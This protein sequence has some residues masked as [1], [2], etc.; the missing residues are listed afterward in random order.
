MTRALAALLVMSLAAC[1]GSEP[2]PTAIGE[3]VPLGP[4]TLVIKNVSTMP[5]PEDRM[6]I[7]IFVELTVADPQRVFAQSMDNRIRSRNELFRGL[8]LVDGAGE[9]RS[10]FGRATDETYRRH[11]GTYGDP[12]GGFRM[13][14]ASQE[15]TLFTEERER[16]VLLTTIPRTSRG[17]VL[18]MRNPTPRE[19]QAHLM[20]VPLGV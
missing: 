14:A 10:I 3:P 9:K 4:Y 11:V 1:R 13:L 6:G 15:N 12:A 20:A 19:G 18:Q 5:L 8:R 17:H 16:W 2:L 7:A